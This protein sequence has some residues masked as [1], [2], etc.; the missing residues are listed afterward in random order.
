MAIFF[1]CVLGD[2]FFFAAALGSSFLS[3]FGA[4]VFFALVAVFSICP[5]F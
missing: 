4:V 5:L 2:I 1:S 3:V